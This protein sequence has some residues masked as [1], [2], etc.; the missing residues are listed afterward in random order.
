MLGLLSWLQTVKWNTA[1]ITGLHNCM[2][3]KTQY[4]AMAFY[5]LAGAMLVSWP[6]WNILKENG[7]SRK[8]EESA[9][10]DNGR[11]TAGNV[12]DHQR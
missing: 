4:S 9:R 12:A 5:N 2:T 7:F 8:W 10:W 6:L 3:T 11:A 1:Y